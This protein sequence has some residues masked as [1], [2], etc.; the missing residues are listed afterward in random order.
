MPRGYRRNVTVPVVPVHQHEWHLVVVHLEDG[1]AAAE[2][3]CDACGSV[4][5]R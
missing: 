3:A 5:F 2:Y 4:D 1:V